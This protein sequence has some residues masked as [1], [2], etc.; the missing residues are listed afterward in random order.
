MLDNSTALEGAVAA[1]EAK[2]LKAEGGIK[3]GEVRWQPFDPTLDEVNF[4]QPSARGKD[5]DMELA[6]KLYASIREEASFL[7]SRFR[8]II[9][10]MEM[11]STVHGMPKGR[12]LS[13]RFLVDSKVTLMGGMMPKRAYKQTDEQID[14]SLAAA[15]V[16]DQS[17]SM[18]GL[19]RDATRIM[20][21]ITEPLDALGCPVMVSG[22]RDGRHHSGD[23]DG[24]RGGSYHRTGS[25]THDVFK[26]FN[27]PLRAVR[28]RFA[29]TR[30]TGGTPM[31]DG[32]Q[33]GLLGLSQRTE[34][35]RI[36]FIVTDGQPNGGHL[37]I[38]R[39]QIRL[40]KD[41]GIHVV[42]VGIGQQARYVRDVFPDS[43]WTAKVADMPAA[44][45]A[46]LNQIIDKT[47]AKRGAKFTG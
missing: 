5:A 31:A 32:V 11:T 1:D 7:R 39:R 38:M 30:A 45:I 23:A 19:L 47:G 10:A 16:L 17:T 36:L 33:F 3:S 6:D 42:G 37:P 2:A 12:R 24:I 4:V 28:W 41:A 8:Q 22:F 46:K 44:L 21:A 35:H 43:V 34:G 25:I 26:G 9:R 29:N 20:C 13:G 15:V 18:S 27:E 14:T 40:A